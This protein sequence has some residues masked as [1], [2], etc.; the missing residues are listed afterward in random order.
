MKRWKVILAT[1]VI[2]ASGFATG[3]LVLP[4]PEIEASTVP[5]VI[6]PGAPPPAAWQRYQ[7]DFMNRLN[8]TVELTP[9]QRRR[10]NAALKQSQER[11]KAIRDKIAPELQE[12]VRRI[13]E[14]IRSELSPE[15]RAAFDEAMAQ[16]EKSAP[17]QAPRPGAQRKP[18]AKDVS[19]STNSSQPVP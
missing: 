5:R 1:L 16:P 14:Q 18:A 4:E 3:I 6:T 8:K 9:E 15:Q 17:A 11:T 19:N 10:I 7:R 13:R 12:E 2:F